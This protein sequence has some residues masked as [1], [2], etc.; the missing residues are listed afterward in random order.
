M[1]DNNFGD[2][3]F[4]LPPLPRKIGTPDVE[5]TTP[6][7]EPAQPVYEQPTYAQPTYQQP[8]DNTQGYNYEYQYPTAGEAVI[9]ELAEPEG[10]IEL[11]YG[12]PD[13]QDE[14]E[15]L[16]TNVDFSTLNELPEIPYKTVEDEL[17]SVAEVS[18]D[19]LAS[20]IIETDGDELDGISTSDMD[21][22]DLPPLPT[23]KK[24]EPKVEFVDDEEFIKAQE[25][26]EAAA[27]ED[28]TFIYDEDYDPDSLDESEIKLGDVDVNKL[29]ADMRSGHDYKARNIRESAKMD[30]MYN[31][32]EV[33]P[34]LAE[35][36]TTFTTRGTEKRIDI[37]KKAETAEKLDDEER[38]SLKMN[39]DAELQSRPV[40]INQRRSAMMENKLREEQNMKKAKKG[41]GGVFVCIILGLV[42]AAISYLYLYADTAENI[43]FL[44]TAVAMVIMSLALFIK[45]KSAKILSYMIYMVCFL[46]YI[47][48][49]AF[50]V[51]NKDV[52]GAIEIAED[53]AISDISMYIIAALPNLIAMIILKKSETVNMYYDFKPSSNR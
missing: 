31:E 44:F 22:F 11:E 41:L 25:E 43:W 14:V 23:I 32:M 49:I 46:A 21:D 2:M 27:Q 10:E 38:A 34:V 48:G 47:A 15:A 33:K 4:D 24:E 9:G 42:S 39:L 5:D 28:D 35:M 12:R 50:M 20:G 53:I 17:D 19:N 45:S 52:E 30:A 51:I 37:K 3:N 18:T 29:T 36:D 26:D 1:P 8:I 40:K 6:A 16:N 7:Y 13:Y